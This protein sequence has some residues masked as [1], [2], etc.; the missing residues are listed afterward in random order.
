[1]RSPHTML[2]A[3]LTLLFILAL[4][5]CGE[6]TANP[7]AD[8]A[9]S[10]DAETTAAVS[11][12]DREPLFGNPSRTQVRISPDGDYLSWLAPVEGVMNIWVAP[13]DALDQA[14]PVTRD[15]GRGINLHY[16]S[17]A[18]P[19]V[20][21]VQDNNGDEN[22]HVYRVDV[23]SAETIDLTPVSDGVRAV[24]QDLSQD[25]PE[26]IMV[27][28]NDR[29]PQL[30]DLYEVNVTSG[31]RTLIRENPGYVSW[32]MDNNLTPRLALR[33]QPGGDMEIIRLG[34]DVAEDSA[35]GMIKAEDVLSA[36]TI[37]F[38]ATNE[39]Y[40]SVD[41]SGR[42]TTALTITNLESSERT[43]LAA[44]DRAD[45]SGVVQNPVSREI[46]AYAVD[47]RRIEWRGLT[48]AATA[49]LEAL[50]EQIPGDL[51]FTNSTRDGSIAIV[52]ADA[53]EMPGVYYLFDRNSMQATELFSTRPDLAGEPLQ[54]MKALE[55]SS[56]D[57]LTL[58][59]YLTLPADAEGPQ[60]MVLLVHGGPWARDRYGYNSFH[61]FLANRGYAVLSVNYRGS[62]GFGKDFVNAAIGEF[63]GK[64]HDDLIDAVNWTVKEG[65]ADPE[66]VAIL[67]GSYGGYAT[68]VG[69]TFTPDTFA[70]GID[71]VGPSNLITLVESF[72]AY[73]GPQ[74]EATWYKF[75]GN[76]ADEADRAD[77]TNRSPITRTGDIKVPLLIGQGENDPRVTKLESDQIVAAMQERGL[78]VTY[79]NYPDEGHGFVR[80]E[81]RMSFYATMEA[82][83]SECLGGRYQPIGSDFEGSSVQVLHGAEFV[84][85]LAEQLQSSTPAAGID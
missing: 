28:L 71:I 80:P 13:R 67:G 52:Y 78:P 61:Q 79:L 57:G 60:P 39:N 21:Y 45:I 9:T 64:M 27:G 49:E 1:M 46:V 33:P 14:R 66:R 6:Q 43:V 34:S 8:A 20:L 70:C 36:Q 85:G 73:W 75:V 40:Y 16:W 15:T 47:Y 55:I 69:V 53:A 63:A 22:Y 65:I 42:D 81:N 5:A 17:Y 35:I 24:I 23:D 74:L 41:S 72:P 12:I 68:L 50:S 10:P 51:A 25:R 84:P 59:S 48:D 29:N 4:S 18:G 2:A 37:G 44:D 11:L 38:D 3:A 30:F 7:P 82:F 83:L 19:Q 54:P 31:E 77:M 62:S 32:V 56:R 26:V 76:P 58:V